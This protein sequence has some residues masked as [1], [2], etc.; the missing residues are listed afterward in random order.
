MHD[1]TLASGGKGGSPQRQADPPLPVLEP[2]G[3]TLRDYAGIIWRRKWLIVLIVVVA[4]ASAFF[5]TSRKT[6]QY[7]AGATMFYRQPLDLANPLSN[8]STDIVSIDRE[9]ATIGDILAGRQLQTSAEAILKRQNV[10]LSPGY[11]ITAAQPS[12]STSNTSTTSFGSNGVVVTGRSASPT[13]AAAAANAFTT[14]YIAWDAQQSRAQIAAAIPAVQRRLAQYATQGA[15]AM[16]STEYILL[17]QQLRDL[18]ILQDT[19]VGN[20]HMLTPATTPTRPVAPNI[21]RATVLG[22]GVGLFVALCLAL[23]LEQFDT[24]VRRPEDIAALLRRP[25]LGRIP[26]ISRKAL[27]ESA[28][29]TLRHP[30]GHVAEAF[31][32]VRTNLEF[33][34]VDD[35]IRSLAVTSCAMG[36][37]KSVFVA[38]L[39]A[40]MAMAGKK[41]VVVDADLRR[42]RQH[43]LFDIPNDRG[44]STALVGKSRLDESLVPVKLSPPVEGEDDRDYAAWARS[45]EALTHL[46]VLPSGPIPPNP[47]EMTS[48][49]RLEMIIE[50]LG[51]QADVV[52]VDTPALL[53]V[54]D[55][56]AI[57]A[58]VDG[59]LLLADVKIVR[60]PQLQAAAEQL[61]RLPVKLLGTVV[62]L[63]DSRSGAYSY[64]SS[65]Y[66]H[67]SRSDLGGHA[68]PRRPARRSVPAE[69]SVPATAST[70]VPGAPPAGNNG[71]RAAEARD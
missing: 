4:T 61:M 67:S 45:V 38:N 64:A 59:I 17:T 13:L 68:A 6:K 33:M 14:A 56:A 43:K 27:G 23:L 29:V 41:V 47:G 5:Y 8:T 19:T 9:M 7:E 57:A 40:S 39:A 70:A 60:R 12:T 15:A 53:A 54:G 10:D 50:S 69:V 62:R 20:Y 34:A 2:E 36:E 3:L 11:T 71:Q 24:R 1:D 42:P 48:S 21:K 65:S 66:Y 37:G 25:T 31:R 26:P 16:D 51:K 22:F 32:M 49:R 63:H 46:L 35:E 44:L 28:L 58:R 52:I 55:T 30:D 18:Q